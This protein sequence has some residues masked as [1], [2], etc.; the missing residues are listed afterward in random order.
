MVAAFPDTEAG[1]LIV[2]TKTP[3]RV[4]GANSFKVGGS[5]RIAIQVAAYHTWSGS[6]V[7]GMGVSPTSVIGLTPEATRSGKD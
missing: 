3:D 6:V 1:G 5:L 7:E 2:G 4:V